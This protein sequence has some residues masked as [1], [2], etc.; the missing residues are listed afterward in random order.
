MNVHFWKYSSCSNDFVVI[1]NRQLSI[2][3]D[4]STVISICDRRNGIGADGVILINE[5][6][7][8]TC[9]MRIYN[10]DGSEAEMCG[11]GIR[12]V[13]HYLRHHET[14]DHCTIQTMNRLHKVS[15]QNELFSISMGTPENIN[16]EVT[17][18]IVGKEY[19]LSFLDTGV[20]HAIIFCEDLD[21]VDVEGI[22][23]QIRYHEYFAPQGT[24]A[25]FATISGCEISVRTYERGVEAETPACGT[26]ATAAAIVAARHGM[27]PPVTV[28][29]KSGD[30]LHIDFTIENNCIENVT[31]TGTCEKIFE[32]TIPIQEEALQH[33]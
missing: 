12:C 24:N 25:T 21:D 20:P 22:G 32:G 15:W 17:V 27:S 4:P 11:N 26:G 8:A 9:S 16:W 5:T 7:T 33:I 18:P 10:S 23:R 31:M 1:D 2:S 13:A 28:R 19:N 29:L 3:L 30:T 14:P 6:A